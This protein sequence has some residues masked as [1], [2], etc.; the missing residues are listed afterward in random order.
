MPSEF[1]RYARQMRVAEVGREMQEKLRGASVVVIGGDL[2]AQVEALYLAGAGV[3]S[4][5]AAA[6]IHNQ[7]KSINSQVT[8]NAN[9]SESKSDRTEPRPRGEI[10]DRVSSLD[11]VAAQIASGALA[12][13]ACM[14]EIFASA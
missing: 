4:I 2:A 8:I 14:K 1:G 6:T 3:G 13:L 7:I 9:A 12:A 10:D 5:C 11:P